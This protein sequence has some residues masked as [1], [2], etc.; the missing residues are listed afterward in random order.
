M[1][2][3]NEDLVEEGFSVKGRWEQMEHISERAPRGWEQAHGQH[4]DSVPSGFTPLS[5]LEAEEVGPRAR[6]SAWARLLAR[7]YE[8]DPL[9]CPECGADDK[10][11]AVIQDVVEIKHILRHLLKIGRSPP[12]VDESSLT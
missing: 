1:E 6:K 8:V 3:L 2:R 10:V 11:T 4:A 7:V 12:G 9:I 5:E